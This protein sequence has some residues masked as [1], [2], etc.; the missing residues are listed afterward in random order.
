MSPPRLFGLPGA[1][2]LALVAGCGPGAPD[3]FVV[4][5]SGTVPGARLRL[6]V[7]DAGTVRC[8]G[9]AP[10]RMGDDQVL[11]ARAIERGLRVAAARRV[12]LARGPD[13]VL[14]YRVRL[15]EGVVSFSD[16]SPGLRPELVRVEGFTRS[17]ATRVCGLVR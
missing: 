7:S 2:A 9:S 17:V 10:R 14:S 6:E 1:A 11:A 12:A 13:S 4:Q 16:T 15:S 5:R 3:L 8:N